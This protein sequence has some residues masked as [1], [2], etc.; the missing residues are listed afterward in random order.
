MDSEKKIGAAIVATVISPRL[1][2]VAKE[3]AEI[4][5]DSVLTDG[6]LKDIP[7]LNTLVAVG[8]LGLSLND[9]VFAKKIFRFLTSLSELSTSE[10]QSMLDRLENEDSFRGEVGGRLI[11]ILDRVDSYSKPE[12]IARAFRAYAMEDIDFD[13]LSRLNFAVE[14]LPHY[15]IKQ[16]RPFF[17]SSAEERQTLNELTLNSLVNAGLAALFSGWNALIMSP[18]QS[19]RHLFNFNW[20]AVHR[21]QM[22][23]HGLSQ[24]SRVGENLGT[25]HIF[26]RPSTV[27]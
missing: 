22:F 20:I 3:Y 15:D 25:D 2:D 7:L 23:P 13:M 4:G 16:V 1:A 17:D 27:K 12:M 9:R 8:R 11:E 21:R 24:G 19:V 10:R 5:I 14:R 6:L 26:P 18:R